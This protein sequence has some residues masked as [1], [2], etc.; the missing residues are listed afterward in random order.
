MIKYNTAAYYFRTGH[1][2]FAQVQRPLLPLMA[3]TLAFEPLS[4]ATRHQGRTS[5]VAT[6]S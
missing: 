4:L 2:A 6:Q 3:H 5:Q 1:P